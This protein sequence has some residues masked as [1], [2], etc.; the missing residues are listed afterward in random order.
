MRV[1]DYLTRKLLQASVAYP[2]ETYCIFWGY[3]L[4]LHLALL[5]TLLLV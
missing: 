1:F 5:V 3:L 2:K 4:G